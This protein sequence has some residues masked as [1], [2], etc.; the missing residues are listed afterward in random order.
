LN[1]DLLW[2]EDINYDDV[3]KYLSSKGIVI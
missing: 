2:Y 3:K 1:K